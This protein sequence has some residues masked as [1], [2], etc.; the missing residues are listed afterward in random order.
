MSPPTCI[1]IPLQAKPVTK[2][3]NPT[4]TPSHYSKSSSYDCHI[5]PFVNVEVNEGIEHVN[6][7]E[8][9]GG[10]GNGRQQG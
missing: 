5:L 6:D 10:G 4:S 3:V 2:V 8:G 7:K 1:I 9:E